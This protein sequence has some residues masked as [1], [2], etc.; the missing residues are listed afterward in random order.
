M[1]GERVKVDEEKEDGK[2]KERKNFLQ[3]LLDLK[4]SEGGDST[5]PFTMTHV[6][7]LLMVHFQTSIIGY[8]LCISFCISF[9][10]SK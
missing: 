10:Q 2:K 6:K 3:F 4:D 7:A 5:T 1:I 9:L 8:L